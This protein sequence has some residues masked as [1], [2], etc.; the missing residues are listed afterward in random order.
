MCRSSFQ[1]VPLCPRWRLLVEIGQKI[2]NMTIGTEK[3]STEKRQAAE[4]VVSSMERAT[5]KEYKGRA[6]TQAFCMSLFPV[7]EE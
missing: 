4:M 7:S 5:Q 2:W 6:D 3:R 1:K